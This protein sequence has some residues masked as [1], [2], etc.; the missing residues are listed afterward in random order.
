MGIF[1]SMKCRTC[2]K[3]LIKDTRIKLGYCSDNCK[4]Q[5]TGGFF[6]GFLDVFV[7]VG[8]FCIII[9]TVIN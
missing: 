7:A 3:T 6:S 4:K 8:D 1:I 2:K 9:F 5:N